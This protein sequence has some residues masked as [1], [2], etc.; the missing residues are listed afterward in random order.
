MIN[1]FQSYS[2]YKLARNCN[3]MWNFPLPID[4]DLLP[5]WLSMAEVEILGTEIREI[6]ISLQIL[7]WFPG[8]FLSTLGWRSEINN[9]PRLS[10]FSQQQQQQQWAYDLHDYNLTMQHCK[11][12]ESM[13][14]QQLKYQGAIGT[15]IHII[16]FIQYSKKGHINLPLVSNHVEMNIVNQRPG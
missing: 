3:I 4:F 8:S 7:A 2:H 14:I 16:T 11:S 1:E 9:E 15:L 10:L 6:V 12:I 13:I 5:G